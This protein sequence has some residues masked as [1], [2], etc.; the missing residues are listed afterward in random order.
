MDV[1]ANGQITA[2]QGAL[3][4]YGD[5]E[6]STSEYQFNALHDEQMGGVVEGGA[7]FVDYGTLVGP[8]GQSATMRLTD[9]LSLEARTIGAQIS[10][11]FQVDNTYLGLGNNSG[12]TFTTITVRSGSQLY[13]AGSLGGAVSGPQG[14]MGLPQPN[15]PTNFPDFALE[16]DV[17]DASDTNNFYLD[18]LTPGFTLVTASGHDYST[19]SVSGAPEPAN[20]SLAS[21]GAAVLAFCSY[22][23]RRRKSSIDDLTHRL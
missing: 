2:Q 15:D 7:L 23:K 9:L 5:V 21:L 17:L 3:H 6:T 12:A 10:S 16:N 8:A 11:T 18:V 22:R 13:I 19:P 14:G 20:I 4:F 1:I